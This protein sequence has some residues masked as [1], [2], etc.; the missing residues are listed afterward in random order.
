[1]RTFRIFWLLGFGLVLA[2]RGHASSALLAGFY[3]SPQAS[4]LVCG[5]AMM[6]G[7]HFADS[8]LTVM[9]E[10]YAGCRRVAL[11]LHASHPT[12]RDAMEARLAAFSLDPVM[13]AVSQVEPA[14]A[15]R[16][17]RL[18]AMLR[19]LKIPEVDLG[20]VHSGLAT[21]G[22]SVSALEPKVNDLGARM[23]AGRRNDMDVLAARFAALSNT[24][25]ALRM[26]DMSPV[27]SRLSEIQAAI[28]NIRM[29]DLAPVQTR[30]GEVQAAVANIPPPNLQPLRNS[31]A[32]LEAF[33]VALDVR[34]GTRTPLLTG[35]GLLI[36]VDLVQEPQRLPAAYNDAAGV[37]AA[38]NLNLLERLNRDY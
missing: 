20:P 14:M 36:G 15:D 21:L 26:P 5:G 28:A 12:D 16:L 8:V 17:A 23:E 18:E 24:L 27:Q 32:D 6:K 7:N 2:V 29:P 37:T 3:T 34:T 11:V 35:G 13:R 31:L 22:L 4:V 38:F 9:R 1:M 33:V 19:D 10:H 25:S 30:L